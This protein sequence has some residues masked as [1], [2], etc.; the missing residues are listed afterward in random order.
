M[1]NTIPQAI[2]EQMARCLHEYQLSAEQERSLFAD[3]G[4]ARWYAAQINS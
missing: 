4:F 3:P 2:Y 1:M